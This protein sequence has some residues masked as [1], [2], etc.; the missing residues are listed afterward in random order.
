M[1]EREEAPR[2]P[3]AGLHL[4]AHEQ[5]L[6]RPA[7]RLRALQVVVRRQVDALALDRLEDQRRHVAARELALER[8]EV[9]E[10]NRVTAS[11]QRAEALAE[12][13]VAVDRQRPSVSPW[14]AWSA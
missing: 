4:V 12:L 2:A 6:G 9:A 3:E 14:K 13:G 7:Q 1:L 10:R 8:I 11:Q 5:R